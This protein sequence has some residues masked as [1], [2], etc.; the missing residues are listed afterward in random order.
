MARTP[1]RP[2]HGRR[3]RAERVARR[4]RNRCPG[5][6]PVGGADRRDGRSRGASAD[7]TVPS[8][9]GTVW[10]EKR[11]RSRRYLN[12]RAFEPAVST[13]QVR[14]HPGAARP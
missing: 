7:G 11:P 10:G 6:G 5:R 1:P 14:V 4:A 2:L 12:V 13:L 9:Y 8:E 3:L